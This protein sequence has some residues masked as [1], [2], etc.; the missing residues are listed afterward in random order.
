MNEDVTN[1]D[2]KITN[3]YEKL[4]KLQN[5]I[6][7]AKL[8]T[9]N[10]VKKLNGKNLFKSL[11][12]VYSYDKPNKTPAKKTSKDEEYYW[13]EDEVEDFKLYTDVVFPL[14]KKNLQEILLYNKPFIANI[15]ANFEQ[16]TVWRIDKT[17]LTTAKKKDIERRVSFKLEKLQPQLKKNNGSEF[18]NSYQDQLGKELF[19][20][21]FEKPDGKEF[22]IDVKKK[23]LKNILSNSSPKT[24]KKFSFLNY[25]QECINVSEQGNDDTLPETFRLFTGY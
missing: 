17:G 4:K 16:T 9:L 14:Q 22:Y 8:D 10:N 6:K 25:L 24:K 13:P 5:L 3:S 11:Q 1:I 2:E 18:V 20:L 23:K 7:N 12:K 21:N 19:I 15:K